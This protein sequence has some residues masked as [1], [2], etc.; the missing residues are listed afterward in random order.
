MW[1][2]I[3]APILDTL[4]FLSAIM[5]HWINSIVFAF[6]YWC[7]VLLRLWLMTHT[8]KL[9]ENSLHFVEF[10][11][12]LSIEQI[13]CYSI[14][15]N[16]WVHKITDESL[17]SIRKGERQMA[18]LN[19]AQLFSLCWHTENF[20]HEDAN[21]CGQILKILW[22]LFQSASYFYLSALWNVCHHSTSGSSR[23]SLRKYNHIQNLMSTVELALTTCNN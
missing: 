4:L 17:D 11:F 3:L 12:R 15:I 20:K 5:K 13:G 8:G 14:K 22:L 7:N 21:G 16:S 10:A 18:L 1:H 6:E 19:I 2:T 9:F 23:Y